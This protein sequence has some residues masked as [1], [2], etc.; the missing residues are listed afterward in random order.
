MLDLFLNAITILGV[1]IKNS[2]FFYQKY[3]AKITNPITKLYW[4]KIS[5]KKIGHYA[6]MFSVQH[7][8][9]L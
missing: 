6:R 5:R 9:Q 2:S 7:S 8:N 4:N 3:I 1:Y